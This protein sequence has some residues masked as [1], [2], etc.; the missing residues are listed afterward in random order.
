MIYD[1]IAKESRGLSFEGFV[2][3]MLNMRGTNPVTVQD[4]KS[5]LRILKRMLHDSVRGL[6]QKVEIQFTK[7]TKEIHRVKKVVKGEV[8]SESDDDS[9]LSDH[10]FGSTTDMHDIKP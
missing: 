7:C 3:A 4:V 5:Q 2:D 9:N 6:E 8:D 1:D 10:F